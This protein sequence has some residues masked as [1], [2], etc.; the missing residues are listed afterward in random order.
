MKGKFEYFCPKFNSFTVF[1]CYMKDEKSPKGEQ[2]IERLTK[3]NIP[4]SVSEK[5]LDPEFFSFYFSHLNHKCYI[6]W[7]LKFFSFYYCKKKV[8]SFY[9]DHLTYHLSYEI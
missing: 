5:P 3:V 8:F 7:F 2:I 4:I 9:F 6:T 1:C